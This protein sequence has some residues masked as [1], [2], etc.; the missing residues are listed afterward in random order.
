MARMSKYWRNWRLQGSPKLIDAAFEGMGIGYPE[1]LK[2]R[3]F[4]LRFAAPTNDYPDHAIFSI[5]LTP[6]EMK[7]I[8]DKYRDYLK[9]Y[10]E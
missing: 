7:A 5:E 9:E 1:E 6:A 4:L 3:K 2:N 10:G 8:A